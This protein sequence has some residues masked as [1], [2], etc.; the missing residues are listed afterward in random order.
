MLFR[1]AV[2]T[3]LAGLAVMPGSIVHMAWRVH[4]LFGLALGAFCAYVLIALLVV[5]ERR[6][7]GDSN[8]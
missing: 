1:I 4:P 5:H 2:L 8:H 3:A 7:R 6:I